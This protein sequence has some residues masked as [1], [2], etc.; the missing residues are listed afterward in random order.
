MV[1]HQHT[2]CMYQ[3]RTHSSH[4]NYKLPKSYHIKL[5]YLF[6]YC[7][8]KSTSTTLYYFTFIHTILLSFLSFFLSFFPSFLSILSFHPF[9][10]WSNYIQIYHHNCYNNYNNNNDHHLHLHY[11]LHSYSKYKYFDSW[12]W[13]SLYLLPSFILLVVIVIVIITVIVQDQKNNYWMNYRMKYLY[14]KKK[15]IQYISFYSINISNVTH[16]IMITTM[17]MIIMFKLSSPSNSSQF[18]SIHFITTT[19]TGIILITT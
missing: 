18:I 17:M 9:P 12:I 2:V 4:H 14:G 1:V 11:H 7:Y 15:A 8:M 5:L 3:E 13:Q 16:T 19:T 6:I 10:C